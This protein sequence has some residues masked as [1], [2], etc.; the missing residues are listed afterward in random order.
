MIIPD[1]PIISDGGL[2]IIVTNSTIFNLVDAFCVTKL[3]KLS[4]NWHTFSWPIYIKII[5]IHCGSTVINEDIFCG[6]NP[7]QTMPTKL[8]HLWA[9]MC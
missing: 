1:N 7:I 3:N 4:K 9:N 8:Y 6:Q 2:F 5:H